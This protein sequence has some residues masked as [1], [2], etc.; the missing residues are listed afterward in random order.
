M[1]WDSFASAT[2]SHM[3]SPRPTMGLFALLIC[4]LLGATSALL[5]HPRI[6]A[7]RGC[8]NHGV[9]ALR[10]EKGSGSGDD[11]DSSGM[12]AMSSSEIKELKVKQQLEA[13]KAEAERIDAALK[14]NADLN[15]KVREGSTQEKAASAPAPASAAV[16]FPSSSPAAAAGAN[17]DDADKQLANFSAGS[18]GFDLG[19]LIA[20]P[21]IIG[22]LGL[23]FVFP[24][25]GERL[26]GGSGPL[27][28]GM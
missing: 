25:V 28:P 11:F 12:T 23:F 21:V 20:F 18:S 27:P 13:E 16:A 4:T 14:K 1:T 24:F 6:L 17:D 19:L 7:R 26:A 8:G 3:T 15:A 2:M 10:L 22:T 9:A 5:A